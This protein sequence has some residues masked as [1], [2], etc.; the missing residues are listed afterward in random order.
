MLELLKTATKYCFESL[1]SFA[2]PKWEKSQT[3]VKSSI[4]RRSKN[5]DI[6]SWDVYRMRGQY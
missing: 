5:I 2:Q 6:T 3:V 4:E 1:T